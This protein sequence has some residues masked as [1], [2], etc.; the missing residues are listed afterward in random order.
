[1]KVIECPLCGGWVAED[2]ELCQNCGHQM[3]GTIQQMAR[4]RAPMIRR[5]R[6]PKLLRAIVVAVIVLVFAVVISWAIYAHPF[7]PTQVKVVVEYSGSWSGAVGDLSHINSWGHDGSYAVILTKSGSGV[8]IISANAQ[9]DDGSGG[10]LRISI[11]N[12]DGTVIRSASTS[13]P[14]GIAQV[15]ISL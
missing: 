2:A 12:M 11:Q 4:P 6:N 7:G 9:K 13:Q 15:A 3:R 1:M 5:Q 10:T 14:F 8:W